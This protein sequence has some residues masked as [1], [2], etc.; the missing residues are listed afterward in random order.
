MKA[1]S[2]D[3][4]AQKNPEASRVAQLSAGRGCSS[5]F[6]YYIHDGIESC[7]LQLIGELT[8]ANLP[9]LSGCWRTARTTLGARSLVLDLQNL[10]R[11]D[12]AGKQ[13]LASMSQEGAVYVP[14][15]FLRTSLADRSGEPKSSSPGL[16]GRLIAL[17]SGGLIKQEP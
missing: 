15:D 5:S 7:R 9:D 13:W 17:F 3:S 11:V 1:N 10:S 12:D 4:K 16:F 6:K 8:E 14:E 2:D